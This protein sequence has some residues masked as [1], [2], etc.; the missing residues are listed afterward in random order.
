MDGKTNTKKIQTHIYNHHWI[1]KAK[2]FWKRRFN[3]T[4]QQIHEIDWSIFKRAQ[5]AS[6]QAKRIWQS[7]HMQNI[8]PPTAS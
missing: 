8:G 7:K 4:S 3:L 1:R 2:K 6:T 5:M